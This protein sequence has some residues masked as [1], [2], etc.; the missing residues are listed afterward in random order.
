MSQVA[1]EA[2]N[3]GE[4]GGD[5]HL[6]SLTKEFGSFT[7]VDAIDLV[8]P[9]GHFFALLGP[10]GCGKTT[11]LRMVAGLETPTGGR[12]MLGDREFTYEKPY[13][14][15]VNTVFQNYALF[16]HLDIF[17]NVAFG[18]RRRKVK[19]VR[20]RVDEMLKLVEL[21]SQSKKMPAQLSGGQQQRVA[22]ARALVFGPRVLL[23]DEP[24]GALD[25]VLREQLQDEIRRLHR[26]LGITVVFVTHDQDEALALS[27]R[28]ALLRKGSIV[29][30]GT[31]SELY[32]KP[33]C[34]YTAEFVGASNIF[35]GAVRDGQFREERT[36]A[37]LRLPDD[38]RSDCRSILVRP[39]HLGVA[40]R[41]DQ[42]G[43]EH[44]RITATVEDCVYLGSSRTVHA[45]T[46]DG[47]V[48][49][50]RTSIPRDP[51]S[52]EPGAR[53]ELYWSVEDVRVLGPDPNRDPSPVDELQR[54]GS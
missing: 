23:M 22:L 1:S 52:M 46:A 16:P 30:V 41:S 5:L 45:R 29:Q 2:R 32:D 44:D 14:R 35:N 7:A 4:G 40:R 8:V 15:P 28:I 9:Q 26:E 34:R 11:T 37:T 21:E 3:R 13:R 24:L 43:P 27:D 17:E 39:E 36:G 18:L 49:T 47:L 51:D 10:S 33:S 25:K 48:L 54:A 20:Q 53:V 6:E 19:D 31:P 12:I 38:A 42:V 50:S